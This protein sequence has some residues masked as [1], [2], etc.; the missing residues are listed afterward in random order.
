MNEVFYKGWHILE[1]IEKHP[2]M[3]ELDKEAIQAT[4]MDA[5]MYHKLINPATQSLNLKSLR[6]EDSISHYRYEKKPNACGIPLWMK[7]EFRNNSLEIS[8]GMPISIFLSN[9]PSKVERYCILDQN[10]AVSAIFEDATFY[11][12]TYDSPTR[13]IRVEKPRQF[14]EI[15]ID[16]ELYLVDV[17]T[18]VLYKSSWF[19]EKYNFKIKS[20]W[21]IN[22]LKDQGK[23][24]YQSSINERINLSKELAS[25]ESNLKDDTNPAKAEK[26]YEIEQSKNYYPEQWEKYEDIVNRQTN[27]KT[28]ELGHFIILQEK[29]VRNLKQASG[30]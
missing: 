17:L 7:E 29:L 1:Y 6:I 2:N 5:L 9:P 25:L 11:N 28:D 27:F 21:S 22:E 8:K 19:K 24:F 12:A 20:K 13:G 14:V 10:I 16:N 4:I 30:Y 3:S 15:N 26:K 23:I 18:K